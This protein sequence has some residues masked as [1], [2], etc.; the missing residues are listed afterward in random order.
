MEMKIFTLSVIL[1]LASVVGADDFKTIEGKEYKNVK[2]SRVEP[3]GIV[4]KSKSGIFKVYFTELPKEVQERFHYDPEQAAAYS[5]QQNAAGEQRQNVRELEARYASFQKQEDE[6]LQ[7]IGQAKEAKKHERQGSEERLS[8][9]DLAAAQLPA[10][11]KHLDDVRAEKDDVKRQL[12]KARQPQPQM[13]AGNLFDG[14]WVGT[15]NGHAGLVQFTLDI[16]GGGTV[17]SATSKLRPEGRGPRD[18]TN[19]GKTMTWYWGVQN[20]EVVTFTPNPDGE[21]ALM[22]SAG[23]AINGMEGYN[24][25]GIFHRTSP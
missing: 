15:I 8:K 18:A 12:Q 21:T 9:L 22:T 4:L 24:A 19:D 23:P 25:S 5:A 13:Q 17:W 10:L 7:G 20:K 16:S 14:R 2:V 6:L 1:C 11:Y 3:D